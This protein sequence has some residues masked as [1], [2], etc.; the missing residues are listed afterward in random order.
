[1]PVR[2][3]GLSEYKKS[4]SWTKSN[5]SR[6]SG[7][8][9]EQ[10]V[11]LAG[12]RSDQLG[13]MKEPSFISKKKVPHSC[14]EISK[15]FQWEW[16]SD[17]ENDLRASRHD[18]PK[19]AGT[20]LP[21]S[22][23]KEVSE[24]IKT[25]TAPRGRRVTRSKSVD[26][27]LE[28]ALASPALVPSAKQERKSLLAARDYESIGD[29][30]D[31]VHR[32]LRKKAGLKVAPK[33]N[34]AKNSEYQ[35]QFVWK[36]PVDNSPLLAAE[37]II[38]SRNKEVPPFKPNGIIHETE[39]KRSFKESPT[40]NR[41]KLRKH[42]EEQEIPVYEPENISPKKKA[43]DKKKEGTLRSIESSPDQKGSEGKETQ[44]QHKQVLAEQNPQAPFFPHRGLGKVNSEYKANFLSP[45]QFK[46]KDG[47]WIKANRVTCNAV[48]ELRDKAEAY[49]RRA[50]GTHFSRDHLNQILSDNNALW[51]V[52]STST[53]DETV[54]DRINALDLARAGG[55]RRTQSSETL[56]ESKSASPV[57][58]P[59][60]PLM[61]S[62]KNEDTGK[63]GMSDLPTLPVR[64]KLAWDDDDD[65]DGP[66]KKEEPLR[67]EHS[68][69][70]EEDEGI[71]E[72]KIKDG[73]TAEDEETNKEKRE[74]P[75]LQNTSAHSDSSTLA[76]PS[77]LSSEEGGRLPTPKLAKQG[78]GQ[79]THHNLTTPAVGGA[80]L[81]S[82]PKM[83]SPSPVHR[84]M[85][86][87]LGKTY[88]PY[89]Y[90]SRKGEDGTPLQTTEPA[91][92]KSYD[93]LPLREE[94]FLSSA[95]AA[96]DVRT[97][98]ALAPSK[99]PNASPAQNSLALPV[100]SLRTS[101]CRIQGTLRDSEFQH[102]GNIGGLRSRLLLLP[103][104]ESTAADDDDDRMSQ[105][106]AR[107]AASS[108]LASEILERA[109]KRKENFWGKS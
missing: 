86:P 57:E 69:G 84:R 79:R 99:S 83:K 37:Q 91:G 23:E 56:Q 29:G 25:P 33:K 77:L 44:T 95:G 88:S 13:I 87:P 64:R 58:R 97:T 17:L 18:V 46:Y 51:E 80:V 52:S 66:E 15:S 47:A 85:Q 100:S 49:K 8:P 55:N 81:V 4:Y 71:S 72:E 26:S 62:L 35:R 48:K 60:P 54:S 78:G 32:I 75:P 30:Q 96:S 3:K 106:S 76:E 9:P 74:T 45:T 16:D 59:A 34:L 31:G 22:G 50:L 14:P 68:Y 36:T 53:T 19:V 21:P 65:E 2:F 10:T 102:N 67:G 43:K 82:P 105:I 93:S 40:P 7:T 39:Y 98:L 24:N 107:S 5:R 20:H 108:S 63:L 109:Q 11:P 70:A 94:D 101:A 38:Y 28:A 41:M 104:Q 1:M 12:L 42:L 61:S 6:D 27:R 73:T 89:K 103:T 90:I 92:V